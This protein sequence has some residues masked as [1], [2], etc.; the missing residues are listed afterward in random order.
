MVGTSHG[1]DRFAKWRRP[2]CKADK[3][4]T[5]MDADEAREVEVG[6]YVEREDPPEVGEVTVISSHHF[7]VL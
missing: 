3:G 5:S 6:M 1:D 4:D 2:V 7:L